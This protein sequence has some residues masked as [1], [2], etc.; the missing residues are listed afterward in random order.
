MQHAC[1]RHTRKRLVSERIFV[2]VFGFGKCH[3]CTEAFRLANLAALFELF[4][5]FQM[6]FEV[7]LGRLA[8]YDKFLA[9]AKRKILCRHIHENCI[10]R[11][12]EFGLAGVHVF[13]RG[14]V[15]GINLEARKDGPHDGQAGVK[16]PVVLHLHVEIG[17]FNLFGG[18]LALA[19]CHLH[20]GIVGGLA[21]HDPLP[22][23]RR[24][25][26]YVCLGRFFVH[27]GFLRLRYG[28][29]VCFGIGA[30]VRG[31][32]SFR[33]GGSPGNI[34]ERLLNLPEVNRNGV[35]D[36]GNARRQTHCREEP[37]K[38][39]VLAAFG[40][41]HFCLFGLDFRIVGHRQ[42]QRIL[43]RKRGGVHS[44]TAT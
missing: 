39:F 44:H 30:V 15:R 2:S 36:F 35:I 16:E 41:I 37:C 22:D 24:F 20:S 5:A 3:F 19:L 32:I 8:H 23:I 28:L 11:H 4:G 18:F 27:A 13:L 6:F 34:A 25:S 43:Q 17:I 38:S 12:L 10:L 40:D 7:L 33:I 42:I 1:K 29:L 14:V 21:I 31:K 26:I 9:Q